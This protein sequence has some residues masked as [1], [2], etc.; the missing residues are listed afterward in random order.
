MTAAAQSTDNASRLFPAR[1]A[2]SLPLNNELTAPPAMSGR[3][4]YF[5]IEGDR[6]A[7]YDIEHGTLLWLIAATPTSQPAIGDGLVFVA[8]PAALT[9]LHQDTGSVAWRVPFSE[10]LSVPLTWDHGWLIASTSSGT[11]LAF[12]AKDGGL[13]WR[14]DIEGGVRARPSLADD[15]IY[16]PTSNGRIVALRVDSGEVVWDRRIGGQPN[17]I[18]ALSDRLYVGS[19]DNY[20]YSLLAPSGEVA[21][22]WPTGGDVIGLPVVD[23]QHV[24]FVSFD[25]VLRALNRKSGGQR[26]KRPLP[27]RPTR[28]PLRAGDALVVSGISRNALAYWLKDGTSAGD[29][30]AGGELATM[31][32]L[33]E[34]VSTP[35]L[36]VVTRDFADGTVLRALT[37][38]YDPSATA[39]GPLP[40]PVMPP[41]VPGVSRPA[42]A[43]ETSA[44]PGATPAT[45]PK[46]SK[47]PDGSTP[48]SL[49]T[50]SV[51]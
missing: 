6:L 50:P 25:N 48:P 29:L 47:T 49:P 28:G 20:L 23:A 21:W 36:A 16:V 38:S 19:T 24:Y 4:G 51:R 2:W 30:P 8:E 26:W 43:P 45:S 13:L 7:A 35:T 42:T 37:R 10:P 44:A 32:Y 27:L 46:T 5:P 40:N 14:R 18:L 41:A 31:P 33:L 11:L 9:A 1:Q 34:G 12:R 3:Y 22:R 15:R 39:V 17:E